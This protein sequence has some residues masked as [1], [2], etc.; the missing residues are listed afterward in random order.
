MRVHINLKYNF[1]HFEKMPE[2]IDSNF[3]KECETIRKG[4]IKLDKKLNS[5]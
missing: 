2:K 4:L 1:L 5:H 3:A